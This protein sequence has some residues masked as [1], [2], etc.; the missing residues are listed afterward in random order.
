M[1]KYMTISFRNLILI[2]TTTITPVLAWGSINVSEERF[3]KQQLERL[4]PS[5][6]D[7]N[8][9][10]SRVDSLS[11]RG[12]GFLA[13]RQD[14]IITNFHVVDR[15]LH[16][17]ADHRLLVLGSKGQRFNAKIIAVDVAA[18]LAVL[19]SDY[20]LPGAVLTPHTE[21]L[22]KGEKLY[23]YG[24]SEGDEFR[25]SAGTFTR[26][27]RDGSVSELVFSGRLEA[28]MSGGPVLDSRGR[29]VGVN[30]S[31]MLEHPYDSRLVNADD[32]QK[33]LTKAAQSPYAS[34]DAAI[35]D[36]VQ[37][38]RDLAAFEVDVITKPNKPK[39][40]LGP[41]GVLTTDRTCDH[42]LY[43]LADER[44]EIYR[45]KCESSN[46][47]AR[48]GEMNLGAIEMRH[49]WLISRGGSA[50]RAAAASKYMM[51]YLRKVPEPESREQGAWI[52]QFKRHT[53]TQSLKIDVQTCSRPYLRIP[54]LLDYRLRAALEVTDHESMVSALEANGIDPENMERLTH[55]WINRFERSKPNVSPKVKP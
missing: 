10:L 20:P 31:I 28:G 46:G 39:D 45:L 26:N 4:R 16:R 36:M 7:I 38:Y 23:A 5:L 55:A 1:S 11:A 43:S 18:D 48:D 25:V 41:F 34:A 35:Q 53:N 33:I 8:L 44:F 30:Q 27:I 51:E 49:Y 12:S 52:C 29:L 22:K 40:W 47:S 13:G 24:K 50:W 54:G 32:V 42:H 3:Q 14:W 17:Y 9:N 37:Q 19:Q 6:I 21:P 2:L 15:K